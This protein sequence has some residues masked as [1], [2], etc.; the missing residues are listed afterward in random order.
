MNKNRKKSNFILD[1]FVFDTLILKKTIKFCMHQRVIILR[2]RIVI[3][4]RFLGIM[5]RC[6]FENVYLCILLTA[7]LGLFC[8]FLSEV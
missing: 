6:L 3:S 7:D 1:L 2:N 8:E 5:D 4:Y